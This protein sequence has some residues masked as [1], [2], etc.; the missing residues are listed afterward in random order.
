[1]T[2]SLIEQIEFDTLKKKY[3]QKVFFKIFFPEEETFLQN[4][5]TNIFN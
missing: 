2:W 4:K 5:E 3:S 1:M